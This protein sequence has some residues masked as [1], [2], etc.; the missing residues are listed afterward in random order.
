[1]RRYT[2]QREEN[3]RYSWLARTL[4]GLVAAGYQVEKGQENKGLTYA[5]TIAYDDIEAALLKDGPSQAAPKENGAGS[6]ERFMMMTGD[7][8]RRGKML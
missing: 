4:G 6:F 5:A 8:A 7:L 2:L 1:M 3:S